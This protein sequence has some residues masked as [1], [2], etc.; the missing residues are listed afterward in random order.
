MKQRTLSAP[1][2]FEGIGLHTGV[3][4][5]MDVLPA[6]E[7][8]GVLFRRTDMGGCEIRALAENI[9]D[10]SRSTTISREG[11]E[12]HTIEH[13]MSALTGMGIDNAIVEIDSKEVPILDGSARLYAEAFSHAGVKE[14]GR[15]RRYIRLD[16][17]IEASDPESGAFVRMEPADSFSACSRID[18]SSDV[19]GVQEASFKEGDDYSAQIAPCRTFV[20]FHE[21]EFLVKN[22]LIKGGDLD[23]AIV[24]VER[25]VEQSQVDAMA[26]ALGKHSLKVEKGYLSNVELH[27]P[28]ECGR[29]KLLDLIGDIRLCGGFISAKVTAYKP[30]HT[31]NSH[32]TRKFRESLLK[33]DKT[34]SV[35]E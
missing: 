13:L 29:H 5:H 22:N 3:Y 23:N 1:C 2:H 14:Q 12:I 28:D 27:F 17:P 33:T 15:D 24:I 9:S 6:R 11:A 7:D 19:L 31:I 34:E 32:L 30:G 18:F 21:I 10:T 8:T 26:K 35:N 4:S 25:T 16:S 20:F